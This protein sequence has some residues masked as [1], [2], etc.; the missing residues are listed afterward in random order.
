MQSTSAS[1]LGTKGARKSPGAVVMPRLGVTLLEV[2]ADDGRLV[3][4]AQRKALE[5]SEAIKAFG[6]L[7]QELG[8]WFHSDDE[9]HRVSADRYQHARGGWQRACTKEPERDQRP[10]AVSRHD[11]CVGERCE[12]VS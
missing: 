12:G 7:L 6:I 5:D 1:G 8:G 2:Q 11:Q 10:D 3:L 4:H 9:V